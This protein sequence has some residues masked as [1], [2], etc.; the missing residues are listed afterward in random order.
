MWAT[1]R[2]SHFDAV[3]ADIRQGIDRPAD[4]RSSAFQAAAATRAP[5]PHQAPTPSCSEIIAVSA[6]APWLCKVQLR[7]FRQNHFNL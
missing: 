1:S 2:H 4:R 7:S 5:R 6:P 3:F